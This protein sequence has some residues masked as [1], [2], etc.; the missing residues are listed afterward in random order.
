M[1]PWW[2]VIC[3]GQEVGLSFSSFAFVRMWAEAQF[4]NHDEAVMLGR[5]SGL[6]RSPTECTSISRGK[7]VT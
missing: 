3:F 5:L 2:D 4:N 1:V 7:M 6:E